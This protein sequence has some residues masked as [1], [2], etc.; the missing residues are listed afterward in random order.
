MRQVDWIQNEIYFYFF[1]DVINEI[2]FDVE[3]F[4]EYF[5]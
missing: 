2:D 5:D 4:Y 3:F 1:E